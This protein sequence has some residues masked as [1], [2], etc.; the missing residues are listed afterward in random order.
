M[1]RRSQLYVPA[2]SEK[3]I[4]KSLEINADSIIFDLE[5][6]VPPEDKEKARELLT[7]LLKELD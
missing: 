7:K 4:R 3:M 5:D 6:S 2:I 1:I